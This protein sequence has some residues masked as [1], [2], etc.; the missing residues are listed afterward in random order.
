MP[1]ANGVEVAALHVRMPHT[2]V[3]VYTI[4]GDLVRESL[5]KI[6]GLAALVSKDEGAGK[7]LGRIEA[8]LEREDAL[9][10]PGR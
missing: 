7:L 5:A 1:T 8:L 10:M 4:Y 3:V 2:Q 6:L 9:A